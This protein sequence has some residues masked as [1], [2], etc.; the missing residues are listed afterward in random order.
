[1]SYSPL[2]SIRICWK[3]C[4]PC[5]SSQQ[6]FPSAFLSRPYA[7][8]LLRRFLVVLGVAI[9]SLLY[10]CM[11]W[12]IC[13]VINH[14]A[15]PVFT[16]S[17]R[18]DLEQWSISTCD[19]DVCSAASRQPKT[20]LEQAYFIYI[21]RRPCKVARSILL[22]YYIYIYERFLFFLQDLK[23]NRPHL[24]P[25]SLSEKDDCDSLKYRTGELATSFSLPT[26]SVTQQGKQN[27]TQRENSRKNNRFC[28]V[29]LF[30]T[31]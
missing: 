3:S 7:Y 27:E 24:C 10:T 21:Y 22:F 6:R 15:G 23:I 26:P 11:D 29:L 30:P 8:V 28:S 4:Q 1:M 25:P 2:F 16:C 14:R 9:S 19:R 17:D 18:C 13:Q 31:L 20:C 12:K 5:S